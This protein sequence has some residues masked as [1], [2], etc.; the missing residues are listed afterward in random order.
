MQYADAYI[1]KNIVGL[2]INY[3]KKQ[4]VAIYTSFEVLL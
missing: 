1:H 4:N 2:K 3:E